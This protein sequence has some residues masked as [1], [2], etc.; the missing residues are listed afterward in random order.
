MQARRRTRI[1]AVFL[2]LAMLFS[3]IG[4]VAAADPPDFTHPTTS[5]EAYEQL[6][7]L[8]SKYPE[9]MAWDN[10]KP[11][12]TA[13]TLGSN[14]YTRAPFRIGNKRI[15]CGVG[16]A[17]YG[18]ELQDTLFHDLPAQVLSRGNF[19]YED[20]RVGDHLR[21]NGGTHSVIVLQVTPAGCV[22]TEANFNKSVHW[23]RV[24]SKAE[25]M[26]ADYVVTRWPA[27]FPVD[28]GSADEVK[29]ENKGTAGS[30]TWE[31][32]NSGILTIQGTG[33]MPNYSSA[34]PAP[35]A[36]LSYNTAV[37]ADGITSIG[38][39]AFYGSTTLNSIT[40]PGTAQTIGISAFQNC[41]NLIS[42][43]IPDG[44]QAIGQEAFCGCAG[45][46]VVDLPGSITKL[47]D[48]AFMSCNSLMRV[49]FA[50]STGGTLEVGDNLFM[51]CRNLMVVVL[52]SN[53]PKISAGMF[54]S[55]TSLYGL[56]IPKTVTSIENLAFASTGIGRSN[57]ARIYFEGSRDDW[58]MASA[59][60]A[61]LSS[62]GITKIGVPTTGNPTPN[63]DIAIANGEIIVNYPYVNPFDASDNMT[64]EDAPGEATPDPTPE[65]SADPAETASPEPMPTPSESPEPVETD[66]PNPSP[67]P[68]E[69]EEPAPSNTPDPVESAS[70]APTPTPTP[71][72]PHYPYYPS[73]PSTPIV[74][75]AP[76]PTPEPTPQPSVTKHF[77]DVPTDF[78][79]RD[80]IDFVTARGLFLGTS[81]DTFSPEAPMTRAMLM[82]VLARLDG[83]DTDGGNTWYAKGIDWAITRGISDGS[84]PSS[85]I[86]REQ[87]ITMLWRYSGS[88]RTDAVFTGFTDIDH[89]SDY[90]STAMQWA[91]SAGVINGFGDGTLRP[92]NQVTR[93]EVAQILQN[94]I[95]INYTN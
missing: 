58:Y 29:D 90:A 36:S 94:F 31:M 66:D 80:A 60:G 67:A 47:G 10:T 30:L 52:P 20:I 8:K 19:T 28:D 83:I 27:G 4:A 56:C 41:I 91:I 93:A 16:C 95:T 86:T 14:Y 64:T 71:S 6:M 22:V 38:D 23:G 37:I 76:T 40:V 51:E 77:S 53:L 61:N 65:I 63:L 9:G 43:S 35:W 70:P 18:F 54:Q 57:A 2:S 69:S 62:L 3:L 87:I 21:I 48:G 68:S 73:Y 74:T 78:W 75:P 79:A 81:D 55:C 5:Q 59:G 24:I 85:N 82:T 1:F 50:N 39:N 25:V 45:L 84:N 42:A 72:T 89:I 33:A 88:P 92:Q 11:Y 44:V 12:G 15:T 34:N 17:G 7:A 46:T 32:T 13:G 49:I 26:D